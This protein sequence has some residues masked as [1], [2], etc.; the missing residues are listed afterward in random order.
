MTRLVVV[1]VDIVL[2]STSVTRSSVNFL[3]PAARG[4]ALSAPALG[5]LA[6]FFGRRP[7]H[8]DAEAAA[9]ARPAVRLHRPGARDAA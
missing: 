7:R 5:L 4:T 9:A 2:L 6:W 3:A 1:D 8:G